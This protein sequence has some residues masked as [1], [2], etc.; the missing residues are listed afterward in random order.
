MAEIEDLVESPKKTGKIVKCEVISASR[1]TDIP[2]FYMDVMMKAFAEKKI[3]ATNQ[4]GYISIISLDPNDAK[5]IVWWSKDYSNWLI[6]YK[7][8]PQIFN[9]YKH[10]FNFTITG[11]DE[12]ETGVKSTLK[13]RLEQLK[14]LSEIFGAR[15]IKYRFD[16]IVLYMDAKTGERKDNMKNFKKIIKYVSECGVKEVIIAFC[17]PYPKV[18]ARM[19]RNGKILIKPSEEEQT[20]ILNG[21]VEFTKK[22]GMTIS[23]CCNDS[24][25]NENINPSKCVD[26]DR[27]EKI[28]KKKL[29]Q[30]KKDKG[31]RQE[32]NCVIS[33]DIGSYEL[34]CKHN[35]MYCYAT[36]DK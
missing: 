33:K 22:Y 1:R 19:K 8:N 5:C 14:E 32:C 25:Q 26:G 23:S 10:M 13:E 34:R 30:N 12:L 7:K 21:M 6:E 27:I 3:S 4:F 17:L 9:Q 18:T 15:T 2:A 11:G 35:C 28:L 36:P 24:I 20:E 16:P 31:Q 29:T